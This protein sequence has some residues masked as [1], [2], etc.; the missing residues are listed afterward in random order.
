MN[1]QNS[2]LSVG[3][4]SFISRPHWR[5]G[6]PR[7]FAAARLRWLWVRILPMAW[8]SLVSVGDCQVVSE[9]GWSFVQRNPTVCGASECDREASMMRKPWPT[10]GCRA[11]ERNNRSYR[12][13][14]FKQE[15]R[16]VGWRVKVNE[17]SNTSS[18]TQ[19][20]LLFQPMYITLSKLKV[21]M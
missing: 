10:R 2:K 16:C 18:V 17:K 4:I 9:S 7:E 20:S 5:R 13:C 21:F 15:I 11:K 1:N 6:L 12:H 14:C 3:I 19:C 8:V